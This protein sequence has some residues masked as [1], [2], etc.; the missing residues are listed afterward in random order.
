MSVKLKN[1]KLG[2]VYAIRFANNSYA[3]GQICEG[4]DMAFFDIQ[5]NQ[6]LT[7]NAVAERAVVFRVFVAVDAISAGEWLFLGIAPLQE[8]LAL[9]CGYRHQPV[10]SAQSYVYV[11][12]MKVSVPI[13]AEEAEPLE[14][15]AVWFSQH[16]EARLLQ[17]FTPPQLESL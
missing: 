11:Q 12:G 15:F 16:I 10:G 14:A 9:K 17:H 2:S 1:K 8:Q 4:G 13:T 6:L 7:P 3:Y 5:S